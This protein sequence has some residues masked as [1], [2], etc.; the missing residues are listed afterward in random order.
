MWGETVEGKRNI[1]SEEPTPKYNIPPH[2]FNSRVVNSFV[3]TR[4]ALLSDK[5]SP[6]ENVLQKGTMASLISFLTFRCH[7]QEILPGIT[8]YA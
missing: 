4:G 5:L 8:T 2:G 7:V 6:F 3:I 1:N